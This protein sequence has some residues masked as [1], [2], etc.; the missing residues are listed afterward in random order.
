M[1]CQ[2]GDKAI[3]FRAEGT[4]MQLEICKL[5]LG[6]IVRVVHLRPPKSKTC[7]A[8]LVWE[9]EEP[10]RVEYMGRTCPV[11]GAGD[12]VLLPLRDPG[13]DAR[14]QSLDWLPVPSKEG[15]T[16]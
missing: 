8:E 3:V 11:F 15:E 14:D 5:L 1:N 7:S 13:E 9:F 12:G 16:A 6:R 4:G 10:V 2:P